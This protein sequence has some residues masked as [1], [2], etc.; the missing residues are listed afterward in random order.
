MEEDGIRRTAFVLRLEGQLVRGAH[1]GDAI[2]PHLVIGASRI[3]RVVEQELNVRLGVFQEFGGITGASVLISYRPQFM[4]LPGFAYLDVGGGF[5]VHCG[6]VF[7]GGG[8]GLRF[9]AF[10]VSLGG[11]ISVPGPALVLQFG[12]HL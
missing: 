9:G 1:T 6:S 11:Q 2:M 7:L 4:F 10:T 12:L 5:G 3:A 8:F